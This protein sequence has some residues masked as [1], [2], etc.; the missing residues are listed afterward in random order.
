MSPVSVHVLVSSMFLS[1][2]V[3][4]VPVFFPCTWS[5]ITC[6][7]SV[8]ALSGFSVVPCLGSL[9]SL[10]LVR[11]H[12]SLSSAT[13]PQSQVTCTLSPVPCP[14]SPVLCPLSPVLC[15]LSPVLCPLSNVPLQCPLY[16]IPSPVSPLQ[17][18]LFSVSCAMFHPVLCPLSHE[19]V[20]VQ[21]LICIFQ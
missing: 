19:L 11:C 15:P 13:W 3:S 2:S 7:A 14:L 16:S 4:V 20:Q 9:L 1:V 5:V 17:S 12:L 6:P 10:S 21:I 18:P 8:V